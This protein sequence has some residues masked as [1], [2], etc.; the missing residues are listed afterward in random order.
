MQQIKQLPQNYAIVTPSS[1]THVN[2]TFS[3]AYQMMVIECKKIFCWVRWGDC[4]VMM[5]RRIDPEYVV[6]RNNGRQ[7]KIVLVNVDRA[8]SNW[9]DILKQLYKW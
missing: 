3:K 8:P 9:H 6:Y 1:V 4:G 2:C 5:K 7:R